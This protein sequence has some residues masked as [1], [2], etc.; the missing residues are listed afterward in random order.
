M[1]NWLIDLV[2][3]RPAGVCLALYCRETGGYHRPW[4][5]A[6]VLVP[7]AVDVVVDVLVVDVFEGVVE[8]VVHEDNE[9]NSTADA[10]ITPPPFRKSRLVTRFLF[11]DSGSFR[12]SNSI[13]YLYFTQPIY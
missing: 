8:E 1:G 9:L 5:S 7:G 4:E 6:A 11:L 10:I 13:S 3:S 12:C 2:I